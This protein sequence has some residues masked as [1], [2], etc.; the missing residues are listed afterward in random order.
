MIKTS[1]ALRLFSELG[2]SLL[3]LYALLVDRDYTLFLLILI[4]ILLSTKIIADVLDF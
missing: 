1:D 2:N 4:V 3:L